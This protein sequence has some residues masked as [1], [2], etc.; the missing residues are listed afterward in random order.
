MG[1]DMDFITEVRVQAEDSDVSVMICLLLWETT[2]TT[3]LQ[4]FFPGHP[5]EPGE[6]LDI[7]WCS[8]CLSLSF[9]TFFVKKYFFSAYQL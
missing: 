3:V 9:V 6:W 4:P 8:V 2:T 5:G 7:L 1:G